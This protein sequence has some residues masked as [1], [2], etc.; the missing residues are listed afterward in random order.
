MQHERQ[1]KSP[2]PAV[3]LDIEILGTH[4]SSPIAEFGAIKFFLNDPGNETAAVS[5]SEFHE[6]IHL[7]G[8]IMSGAMPDE[9]AIHWWNEQ[10]HEL[11]DHVLGGCLAASKV[12]QEFLDWP[13]A[14]FPVFSNGPHFDFI[15]L[16]QAHIRH[17]LKPIE[18]W[19]PLHEELGGKCLPRI[20]RKCY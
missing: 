1:S 14:R 9:G 10:P 8:D 11:M 4:P 13:P 12:M 2:Q 18:F 17:G 20:R 5:D 19:R 6:Q 15:I 3:M 7:L 16:N